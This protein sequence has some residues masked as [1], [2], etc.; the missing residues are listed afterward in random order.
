[1]FRTMRDVG[2][3]NRARQTAAFCQILAMSSW[4]LEHVSH[5]QR[6]GAEHLAYSLVAT[7]ELQSQ[8]NDPNQRIT[9]DAIIAVLV[10]VC[11]AVSGILKNRLI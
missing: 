10:F 9:D 7:R 1:M 2:F 3:L 8:I 5:N 6:A 11:C 4:H